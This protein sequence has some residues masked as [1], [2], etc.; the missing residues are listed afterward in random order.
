VARSEPTHF[1]HK[2]ALLETHRVGA[3]NVKIVTKKAVIVRMHLKLTIKFKIQ[4]IK[5]DSIGK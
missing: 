3:K 5:I 1:K 4:K 2:R